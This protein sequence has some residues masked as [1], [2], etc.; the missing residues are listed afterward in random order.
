[1]SPTAIP[2][3]IP[4]QIINIGPQPGQ[5]FVLSQFSFAT[6]I[7]ALITLIL[8]IAAIVFV[9]ML[10]W[11]GFRYISS[12]GDKAQLEQ[13]RGTITSALIGLTILFATWAIIN[14]VENFFGISILNL[15]IPTAAPA[16]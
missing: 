6:V 11:G 3:P 1:M 12:S 16:P 15:L 2:T 13:A 4:T 5:W 14:L 7:S 9:F 10:L 8:V